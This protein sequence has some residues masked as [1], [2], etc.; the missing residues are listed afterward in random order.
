MK[1][2][3]AILQDRA[4]LE[5]FVSVLKKENVKSYLEI[6]SKF[7]GSL[8]RIARALPRGSRIVSVDLPFGDMSFKVS[9][10]V[11]EACVSHLQA[12]GYDARL[13]IGDSTDPEVVAKAKELGP[14]DACLIDANHTEPYV[15]QDWANY[16]PMCRIVAFHDIAWIKG[17]HPESKKYPIEVKQV[18]DEIKSAYHHKEICL[19][20][21]G[22][23]NG[24]GVLWRM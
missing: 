8:W 22:E 4:E 13:I 20:R 19:C 17:R 12:K 16:G 24:F 9:Q 23:D 15:R 21:T 7:G 11:L 3:T 10:P 1:Y 6:G 18:W 14:F 2:E 5:A